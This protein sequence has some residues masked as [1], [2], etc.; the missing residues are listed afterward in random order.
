MKKRR[1]WMFQGFYDITSNMITQNRNLN[2][3]SN[4]MSNV[5]TPG[6]KND[7]VI[8]G[9]FR[10][11][12]LYRYDRSGKT[13][14]GTVSRVNTISERVTDYTDGGLR[15]T[16]SSLHAGIAGNGFFEIQTERGMVYSRN[17]SFSVDEQG[18]LTLQGV[19]RVMGTNGGPIYL[20]TDK[21]SIDRQ[22]NIRDTDTLQYRG[23]LRIV[24]FQEYD[25]LTKA[26][27]GV[28]QSNGAQEIPAQAEVI[29]K[30]V[31]N[32]NVQMAREMTEMMTS[33]R[34]LQSSSQ[35]LRMYDQLISKA[36]QIGS[37]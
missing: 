22:G 16:G 4:N 37:M 23:Q 11:E 30:Y 29:Q 33:Q 14:V 5:S 1:T 12:L 21:I 8:Q 35:I 20:E 6:Y 13:P 34:A 26:A 2:V 25:R 10:D 18:C 31:E 24:D 17:G 19:G 7:R 27:G 32:S 28:F 9:T 36:V 3:I 15:E